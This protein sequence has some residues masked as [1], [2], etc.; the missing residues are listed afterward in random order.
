M[1]PDTTPAGP[2]CD[3][4]GSTATGSIDET[5]F[6]PVILPFDCRVR[7]SRRASVQRFSTSDMPHFGHVPGL[8]CTTSGC[9]AHVYW[10]TALAAA[11]VPC[12]GCGGDEV[13]C[14]SDLLQ[15]AMTIA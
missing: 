11:L 9:I 5:D 15:P 2:S 4:S 6:F 8:F 3:P 13:D 12:C 7:A 10:T 14:V 1:K